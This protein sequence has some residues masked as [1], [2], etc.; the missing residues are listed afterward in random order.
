MDQ[1]RAASVPRAHLAN[2]QRAHAI[3]MSRPQERQ[4]NAK[5]GVEHLQGQGLSRIIIT[6]LAKDQCEV[7]NLQNVAD[8]YH[9]TTLATKQ[10]ASLQKE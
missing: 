1:H 9:G 3:T 10:H 6:T 8:V 4:I 7:V 5:E 2:L